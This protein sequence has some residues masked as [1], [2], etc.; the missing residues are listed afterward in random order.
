MRYQTSGA[1]MKTEQNTVQSLNQTG[2][3]QAHQ[4]T[5]F[6]NES[7]VGVA[8]FDTQYRLLSSN[9]AYRHMRGLSSKRAQ[10]GTPIETIVGT[11]LL[12][13]G[14]RSD[15]IAA[16]IE[17]GITRLEKLRSDRFEI[18]SAAGDHV[19]VERF[20]K[21]SGLLVE[22][23]T[24]RTQEVSAQKDH[25]E[26]RK[27]SLKVGR[28]RLKLA[29]ENL[30]DGFAIFDPEGTLVAVNERYIDLAPHVAEHIYVGARHKDI[31]RAVYRSGE[32]ELGNQTEDEFVEYA[33]NELKNPKEPTLDQL[34][35]GRWVRF[36]AE[37][38][39]DGST[40][41]T[42]SDVTELKNQEMQVV[43]ADKLVTH[44]AEQ[45]HTAIENMFA[46][47]IMFD[48][49]HR[50]IRC[51]RLYREIFGFP[52]DVL[53]PGVTRNELKEKAIELGI[54]AADYN[55]ISAKGYDKSIE[56]KAP[57]LNH[58]K[59]GDGRT[60][61][62]RHAPMGEQGSLVL[63]M[64]ITAERELQARLTLNNMKLENSNSE[65]QNFAYVASHDLQEPL[66]K[67]EAFSDRL[68][69]KFNAD[70]PDDGQLYLDRIQNAAGRMRQLINDLL[71]F[72]RVASNAKPF[73]KVD[74]NQVVASVVDDIQMRLEETNATVNFG[75]LPTV[76]ADETQMRQLFQNLISNSLKFGR[77]DVAPIVTIT[78]QTINR[79]G[80]DGRDAEFLQL[81]LSDNGIGFD[82]RFKDQI[83][84][85]FQRL[86]GRMEYEGT[87]IGLATCRKIVDRH[88]GTISADGVEN[89]G[90]IFSIELPIVNAAS[91]LF[92]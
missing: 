32:V 7:E 45:L 22:T 26:R 3:E 1:V 39:E 79:V 89:V 18:E 62:V 54:F 40:V 63:F 14:C 69:T 25:L 17:S 28:R 51:N 34:A 71:S 66:R 59:L 23:I 90:A 75:D 61:Q 80:H 72:S 31:I 83:F 70:L 88:N 37:S 9:P 43:E 68:I 85:I 10:P 57:T 53:Q 73:Q 16:I 30:P 50:M 56:S 84:A 2:I 41:F 81:Q 6:M 44:G 46:G 47:L 77:V 52:D 15:Q 49:D 36:A 33:S 21:P 55:E 35:D 87:G 4:I 65:L 13:D 12:I 24:Q 42:Q 58:Y 76:D 48:S 67:I 5:S 78:T 29:L 60:I 82:N 20:F 91:E 8:V 64:D 38:L 86:H 27:K 74:L 19:Y 92:A 11:T